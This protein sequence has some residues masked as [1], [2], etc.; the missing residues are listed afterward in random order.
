MGNAMKRVHYFG[1]ALSVFLVGC[2]QERAVVEPETETA[3][4]PGPRSATFE[5]DLAG[6]CADDSIPDTATKLVVTKPETTGD[7]EIDEENYLRFRAGYPRVKMTKVEFCAM[8][9]DAVAKRDAE[10]AE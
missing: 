4:D 7:P 3:F 5:E 1:I 10:T 9:A 2:G 6:Y 8:L